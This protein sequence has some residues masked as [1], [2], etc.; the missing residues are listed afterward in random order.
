[1][2]NEANRA[3]INGERYELAVNSQV[4]LLEALREHL[5]LTGTKEECELGGTRDVLADG[6]AILSCLTLAVECQ[7]MAITTI[8]GLSGGKNVLTP[9]QEIFLE[10]GAVQCGFGSPGHGALC[11][12][13]APGEQQSYRNRR[14]RRWKEISA[15]HRYNKIIVALT[16]EIRPAVVLSS[17]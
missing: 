15:G 4:T 12:P 16:V 7:G 13:V 1:M 9:V 8:E 5:G 10:K 17:P 6:K 3:L 14:E 2:E 11:H